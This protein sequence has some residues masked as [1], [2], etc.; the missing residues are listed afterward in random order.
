M[1]EAAPILPIVRVAAGA[2]RRSLPRPRPLA[3]PRRVQRLGERTSAR[4][5]DP[6][7]AEIRELEAE[8]HPTVA[9]AEARKSTGEGGGCQEISAE[10]GPPR[11]FATWLPDPRVRDTHPELCR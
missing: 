4:G 6:V 7:P 11:M 5:R 1:Y 2:V 8:L 3:P 10:H 9:T